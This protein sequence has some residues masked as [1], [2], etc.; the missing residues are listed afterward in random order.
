MWQVLHLW[1]LSTIVLNW[2]NKPKNIWNKKRL[3]FPVNFGLDYLGLQLSSL[4]TN[5]FCSIILI[6]LSIILYLYLALLF[7]INLVIFL[8][9]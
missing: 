1:N 3:F 6:I 4:I 9:F 5:L 2:L 8:S 7:G